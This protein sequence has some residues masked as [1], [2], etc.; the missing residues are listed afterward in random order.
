MSEGRLSFLK[1]KNELPT[2]GDGFSLH[3]GSKDWSAM[4]FG[5]PDPNIDIA[6]CPLQPRFRKAAARYRPVLS[7]CGKQ[8]DS[9]AST[10]CR[11]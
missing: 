1:Q 9:N 8:Y 2:L 7:C 11:A 6:I 5:H 3:I 4:W 10:G